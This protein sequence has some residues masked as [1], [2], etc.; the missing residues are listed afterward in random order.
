MTGSG[1]ESQSVDDHDRKLIPDSL[2]F[3]R[4]PQKTPETERKFK[5]NT[6]HKSGI[7]STRTSRHMENEIHLKSSASAVFC[8]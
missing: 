1:D 6:R 2:A 3:R 7:A 8:P 4:S 5:P